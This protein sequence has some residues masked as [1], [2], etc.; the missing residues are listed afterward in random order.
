MP[1]YNKCILIGHL[2]RDPEQRFTTGNTAVCNFTVASTKKWKSKDGEQREDTA[3][4]DCTAWGRTGEV[5]NEYFR[6]GA[7]ILVEGSLRTESWESKEGQKR[8]KL[9]LN[10][11]SFSFIGSKRDQDD[12]AE[13]PA[14]AR[15]MATAGARTSSAAPNTHEPVEQDDIPF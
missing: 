11:E 13:A 15:R 8:S 6:K 3:F 12:T 10:V 4:V 5:I 14:N 1:N 2:C 9:V 7:A